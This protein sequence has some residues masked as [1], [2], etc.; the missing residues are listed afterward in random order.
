M[1][2]ALAE[3]LTSARRKLSQLTASEPPHVDVEE[4]ATELGLE[5][6]AGKLAA[7]GLPRSDHSG[8]TGIEAQ[9]V[10]RVEATRR[11]CVRWAT[12]R[13]ARLNENH[14]TRDVAVLASE[15]LLA[16]KMFA[17]EAETIVRE[18]EPLLSEL[19]EEA[20]VRDRELADFRA[21]HGLVRS[22]SYPEGSAAFARYAILMALIVVEGIANAYFFSQG[23]E[24]GL[25]GGF[26]AAGLFA[27]VNL[28]TAFVLGKFALPLV[29]HRHRVLM[30]IGVAAA[31]FSAMWIVAVGLTIAHFRD[32][33]TA[34][35]AEPAR[36]AWLAFKAAPYDL[37]DVM[38]WLLF[39]ISVLFAAFALF[40]G[41]SSDDLYP[42]YG[43]VARRARQSRD[44]YISELQLV[45]GMLESAKDEALTRIETNTNEARRLI[46]EAEQVLRDKKWTRTQLE[47]A[48][49]DAENC[50]S[51]LLSIF[52]D[53]N[54][55][56]R[57]SAVMPPYFGSQ[58][59]LQRLAMPDFHIDEDRARLEK[60]QRLTDEMTAAAEALRGNIESAF[61]THTREL[62]PEERRLASPSPRPVLVGSSARQR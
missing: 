4:I 43:R 54:R 33:L 2:Q 11:D 60:A 50:L 34:D 62:K 19:A 22:A 38:S 8:L 15:A 28:V 9:A 40:D 31:V 46:A 44:D 42:G 52:R 5:R 53:A 37:R 36:A 18:H 59:A 6:E 12:D 25:L 16:D 24:S 3:G 13:L 57:E 45:R 58:P 23:L 55:A 41:L 32:A 1:K 27:S 20:N 26:L 51:T 17:R 29:F 35:A 39:A 7:A 30:A 47:A 49:M 61:A 48:L 14:R 56:A 21:R 10:Q